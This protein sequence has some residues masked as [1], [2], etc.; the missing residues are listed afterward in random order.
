VGP[1]RN[2]TFTLLLRRKGKWVVPG[3]ELDLYPFP[4]RTLSLGGFL[5]SFSRS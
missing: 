5:R 4:A 2:L 1:A 3:E